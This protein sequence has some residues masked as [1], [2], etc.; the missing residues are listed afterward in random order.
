MYIS[1]Q[2]LQS[3]HENNVNEGL[4]RSEQR[5]LIKEWKDQQRGT[6][7]PAKARIGARTLTVL[8]RSLR[9]MVARP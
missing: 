8:F 9:G 3:I 1:S 4:K 2:G 7:V 5:R 6:D